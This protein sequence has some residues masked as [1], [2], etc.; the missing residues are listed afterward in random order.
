MDTNTFDWQLFLTRWSEEWAD[1]RDDSEELRSDDVEAQRRRWLGYSPASEADIAALEQ[2]LGRA[3]PSSYR[4][5]LRVS[6]GWRHAGQFVWRVAGTEGAGWH[7]DSF[8]LGADFDEFWGEEGNPPHVRAQVGLWSRALQVDAESDAVFVLLDPEDVGPDGEWAVRTWAG[9]RAEEPDRYPS[10]AHFMVAMHQEFHRH[11]TPADGAPPF[12]DDTT[13]A[14]DAAVGRARTAALRGRPEEAAA[15]LDEAKRYGRPGAAD[16]LRQLNRFGQGRRATTTQPLPDHPRFLT[17]LLPLYAAD[18]TSGGHGRVDHLGDPGVFPHS[19]Q[20]SAEILREVREGTYGYR[21][22]GAFGE[23]VDEAREAARW[24]DSA[25]AWRILRAA[26]PLWQPL[27]PDHIAPEGLFADVLLAPVLTPERCRELLATPRGGESG[28]APDP[29]PATQPDGLSWVLRSEPGVEPPFKTFRMVLV[30]GVSPGGLPGL[31]GGPDP[32]PLAPPLRRWDL[33]RHHRPGQTSFSSDDDV[34]LLHVGRAGE[35][36]S[37]A[38]DGDMLSGLQAEWFVSPAP[39]A[40]AGGRRAI[41]VWCDQR[42]NAPVFHLSVAQDGVLSF[43][44]T[45]RGTSVEDRTGDVPDE[46]A[47]EYLGFGAPE[48]AGH[49]PAALHTLDV[50]AEQYGVGLPRTA[51]HHGRLHS[52]EGAPWI[53]PPRPGEPHAT[54]SFI[55][56]R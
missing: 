18:V 8:G 24:G 13:R 7:E 25:E 53:R 41:V 22:G 42:R 54:L 47:P 1:S 35:D 10:F 17:E 16:M 39:A 37:F 48:S 4:E 49:R 9:W 28:P 30:E 33:R 15:L 2:R 19:A 56:H 11:R 23:A 40:S 6:D 36:W 46:L 44:F 12:V 34:V 5:F 21:P 14:Q 31:L 38:F 3:L 27:D 52:F 32:A 20:A 50:L 51:L 43:G 55:R 29:A 26:L 45:V